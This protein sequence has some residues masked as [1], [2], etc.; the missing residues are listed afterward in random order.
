MVPIQR[1]GYIRQQFV[2]K[3]GHQED[4][5]DF[6]RMV[7]RCVNERQ[8]RLC[9]VHH[10]GDRAILLFRRLT[11]HNEDGDTPLCMHQ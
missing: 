6:D 4:L 10:H 5:S 9:I 11:R 3:D 1:M 7:G 2:L 8:T